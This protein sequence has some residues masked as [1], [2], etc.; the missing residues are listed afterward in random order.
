MSA[1][2][3]VLDDPQDMG[4]FFRRLNDKAAEDKDPDGPVAVTEEAYSVYDEQD[5]LRCR[6][7]RQ[8][9]GTY[10]LRIW[11]TNGTQTTNLT[12]SP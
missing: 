1:E 3:R 10:G 9:D 12:T 8:S 4:Q 6:L 2:D 5:Q 7:G 11:D